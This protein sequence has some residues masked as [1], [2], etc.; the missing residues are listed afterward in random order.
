MAKPKPEM[1]RFSTT[2]TRGTKRAAVVSLVE[3]GIKELY[4]RQLAMLCAST[5][6]SYKA[7]L[8]KLLEQDTLDEDSEANV[9]RKV[10]G[11]VVTVS[12]RVA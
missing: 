4:A 3:T 6:R 10:R 7:G 8:V 11:Q 9:L 5:E 2:S 1:N 12:M